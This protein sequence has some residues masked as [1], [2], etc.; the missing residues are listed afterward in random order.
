MESDQPGAHVMLKRSPF[1]RKPAK[2]RQGADRK[3]LEACR[4]ESCFLNLPGCRHIPNDETVVPAHRNEGKGIG[5][6]VPDIFTVPACHH[7]HML[8]DQSGLDR[9]YK[10][11]AWDW[12]YTRWEPVRAKKMV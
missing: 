9:E 4:G 1:K 7:C 2:K 12:A 3:Y 11:S 5:L 8:Y 10:R 6:K